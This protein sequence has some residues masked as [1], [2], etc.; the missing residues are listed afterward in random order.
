MSCS[1]GA[2][3]ASWKSAWRALLGCKDSAGGVEGPSLGAASANPGG[4]KWR[5]GL[6]ESCL[7]GP[8]ALDAGGRKRGASIGEQ[9][10]DLGRPVGRRRRAG[11]G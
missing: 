4:G 3:G 11:L 9:H 6:L 8:P 5:G 10:G 7:G 2:Q 1:L